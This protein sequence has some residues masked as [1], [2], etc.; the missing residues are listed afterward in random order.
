[1]CQGQGKA[2]AGVEDRADFQSALNQ[3]KAQILGFAPSAK[4]E[5]V[6]FRSVP[7][8]QPTAELP[9]EDPEK[10]EMRRAKREKERVAAWKAQQEEEENKGKKGK[11]GVDDEVPSQEKVY[12]DAKGKRKVAFIKK[13][14]SSRCLP[15]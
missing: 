13:D 12:I 7:F 15:C 8:A 10:D 4:I 6:R 11:K 3:L 1:M 2:V 9:S 14:V 5:A